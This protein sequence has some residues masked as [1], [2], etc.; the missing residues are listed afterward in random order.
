MTQVVFTYDEESRKWDVKVIGE[1]QPISAAQAFNA[2]VLTCHELNPNLLKYTRAAVVID[3]SDTFNIT[4][5]C[6]LGPR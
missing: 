3:E 4:P 6:S 1:S 2:V 5:V